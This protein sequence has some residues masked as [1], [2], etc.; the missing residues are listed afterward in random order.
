MRQR[1]FPEGMD[2]LVAENEAA[3][4]QE[5]REQKSQLTAYFRFNREHPDVANNYTYQT[6]GIDYWYDKTADQWKRRQT[7]RQN[8]II[9]LGSVSPKNVEAQV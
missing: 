4:M 7:Q 9:R 3:R 5:G 2:E 8:H 1:V 6:I